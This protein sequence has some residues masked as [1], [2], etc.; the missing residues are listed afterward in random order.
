MKKNEPLTKKDRGGFP[1]PEK[2]KSETKNKK[3][4]NNEIRQKEK[5]RPKDEKRKG[6]RRKP[7]LN[8]QRGKPRVQK[9]PSP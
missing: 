9:T 8:N 1:R 6:K 5:K 3:T 2:S 4:C 7:M